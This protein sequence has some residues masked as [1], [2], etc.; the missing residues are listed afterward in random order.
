MKGENNGRL[1]ERKRPTNTKE[2]FL[3]IQVGDDE[4]CSLLWDWLCNPHPILIE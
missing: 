1:A 4:F 2:L 3:F